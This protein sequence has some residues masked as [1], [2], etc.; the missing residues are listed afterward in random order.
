MSCSESSDR[1]IADFLSFR[2]IIAPKVIRVLYWI[3]V[4]ILVPGGIAVAAQKD[5]FVPGLLILIGG[6]IIA[7][8]YAE[9]LL[10]VFKISDNLAE[11]RNSLEIANQKPEQPAGPA[12][13]K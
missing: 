3:A 4:V 12:R 7:R 9:L 2:K 8:V 5:K 10:T 6:P 11:I 13:R 1:C